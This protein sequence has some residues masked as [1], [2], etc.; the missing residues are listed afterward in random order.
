[1]K[2]TDFLYKPYLYILIIA[3]G[4]GLKFYKL[5]QQFFWDDE[6]A[7]VLHTSGISMSDYEATIPVNKIFSESFYDDILALNDRKL[8][9]TD[10]IHGLTMMPQLTP[11]HYYYLIFWT[12]IFG[13]GYMS[14]RYFSVLLFL[15]SLPLLFLLAQKLFQ[16]KQAAWVAVSLYA[17]S[18]FFQ[19]YAQEARYYMLWSFAIITMHY[20]LLM[21]CEKQ[22]RLWWG[23]Y[24]VAGM[25][26]VHTTVMFSLIYIMHLVYYMVFYAK[27]W[28]PLFISL[29]I[30]FI[31]SLPWLI[32]IFINRIDIQQNLSWHTNA[33]GDAKI[34]DIFLWQADAFIGVFYDLYFPQSSTLTI[35]ILRL[36]FVVL[37]VTSLVFLVKKGTKKQILFLLLI[38]FLGSAVMITEDIIRHSITSMLPR[39]SLLNFIGLLLLFSFIGKKILLKN[40]IVYTVLFSVLVTAAIYS[41]KRVTDDLCAT[42]RADSYFH[43]EDAKN[44]LSGNERILIISDYK[45]MGPNA[46][47]MFMSL[48]HWSKNQHIDL[49]YPKTP[50]PDFANDFDL[51]R[52]DKVYGMYLSDNLTKQ[53]NDDFGKKFELL[54]ERNLYGMVDVPVYTI[55]Q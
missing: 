2:A 3:I 47:S 30:I 37:I 27:K 36:L 35:I 31:S 34:Y 13:D 1:M 53:L 6:I 11:G 17:I 45:L 19:L 43:L 16:S 55:V 54:I 22:S 52:Y 41:S 46:Y 7:T 10:Q 32:F 4:I 29:G 5:D 44:M 42:D 50:F 39:Y 14:Y 15:L 8:N 24:I 38:T 28:K 25:F 12:R 9:V 26:A 21:A 49:I 48:T 20:L 51:S 40:P 18:P 33:F 23:I